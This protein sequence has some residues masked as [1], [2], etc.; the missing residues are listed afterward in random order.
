M[1]H[2]DLVTDTAFFDTNVSCSAMEI[3]QVFE[4]SEV[5]SSRSES[6][7]HFIGTSLNGRSVGAC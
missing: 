6:V 4:F 2:L 7:S 1:S 3:R 5:K